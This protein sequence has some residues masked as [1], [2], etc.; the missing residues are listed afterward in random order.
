MVSWDMW[1]ARNGV[2]HGDSTTRGEQIIAALD[3]EIKDIYTF[4]R[5]HQFLT[6]VAKH[7]FSKDL[8]DILKMSEH[9]KKLWKRMGNKHLD[10]DKRRMARNKEAARM[11]EW[12]VPGSSMG[13]K[14]VRNRTQNHGQLEP[15]APGGEGTQEPQNNRQTRV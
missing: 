7:F 1:D 2:V 4:G 8:T 13:R 5:D 3:A 6:P 10:N 14:R 11:R 9:Q 12:L 15:G